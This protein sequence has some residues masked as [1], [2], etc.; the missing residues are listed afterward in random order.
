MAEIDE[1]KLSDI[2]GTLISLTA[3]LRAYCYCH[4]ENCKEISKLVDF[5]EILDEKSNQLFDFM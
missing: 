4:S 2:A 1:N 3:V 5:A